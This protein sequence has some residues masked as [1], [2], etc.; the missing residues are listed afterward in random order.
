M[1]TL[2]VTSLEA[3]KRFILLRVLRDEIEYIKIHIFE[4]RK[5]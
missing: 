5:K 4:L 1:T 3:N 2:F